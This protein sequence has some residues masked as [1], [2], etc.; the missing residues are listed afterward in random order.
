MVNEEG[1]DKVEVF[2]PADAIDDIDIPEDIEITDK[3]SKL[4]KVDFDVVDKKA[5]PGNEE[6]EPEDADDEEADTETET[7]EELDVAAKKE[8][9]DEYREAK[10]TIKNLAREIADIQEEVSVYAPTTK[11][12]DD[13]EQYAAEKR[14]YRRQQLLAEKRIQSKQ[15]KLTQTFQA[16]QN[17]FESHH[18]NENLS[19]FEAYL[20]Q[21]KGLLSDV[22]CGL[23][24]LET[25]YA[26]YKQRYGKDTLSKVKR[27]SKLIREKE[28]SLRGSGHQEPQGSLG[29]DKK[30]TYA[31]KPMFKEFVKK[32]LAKVRRGETNFATGRPMTLKDIDDICKMEYETN[33]LSRYDRK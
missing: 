32:E 10:L 31:S 15:A 16:I 2:N 6:D 24:D 21:R 28:P 30:Y 8:Y 13:P 18:R 11:E 29:I 19:H 27:Q 7:D 25:C 33:N 23:E 20:H 17:E 5:L 14:E 3:K 4:E 1:K 9:S 26:F 12:E 22:L